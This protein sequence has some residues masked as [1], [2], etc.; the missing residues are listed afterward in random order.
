MSDIAEA[1][2]KRIYAIRTS[3][4]MSRKDLAKRSGLHLTYIGQL[5][6]GERNATIATLESVSY[7]LNV[8]IERFVEYITP[9]MASQETAANECYNLILEQTPR[10]QK[11]LLALLQNMAQLHQIQEILIFKKR[12]TR[13]FSVTLNITCFIF[14]RG[15]NIKAEVQYNK[16]HQLY[17]QV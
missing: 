14:F 13:K 7:A 10:T 9:G 11:R 8:P 1:V 4:H 15:L 16:F 12:V 3:K 17:F 6:R 2:G 5:E